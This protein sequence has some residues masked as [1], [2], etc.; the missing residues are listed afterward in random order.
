M[1][2]CFSNR[3]TLTFG[4]V[5]VLMVK[6]KDNESCVT[7][8]VKSE[9]ELVKRFPGVGQ[10][11]NQRL[12]ALGYWRNGR[13]DVARFCEERRYRPQ[14]VYAWLKDRL[15]DYENL[16]RLARDLRAPM[17]WLLLGEEGLKELQ[18]WQ[19]PGPS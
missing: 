4:L 13:P 3:L 18:E 17:C 8:Q 12:N 6:A 16:K 15:P 1:P 10:R 2:R 9:A 14:Y 7:C 19:K 11:I 5:T